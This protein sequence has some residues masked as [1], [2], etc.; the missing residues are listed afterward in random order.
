MAAQFT[1]VDEY[2]A[3]LPDDVGEVLEQIRAAIHRG[4]PGGEEATVRNLVHFAGLGGS[5]T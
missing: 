3:S 1:T 4:A 2:I 5:G